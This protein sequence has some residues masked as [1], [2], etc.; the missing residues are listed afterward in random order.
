MWLEGQ[1]GGK[2]QHRDPNDVGREESTVV[3]MDPVK[4]QAVPLADPWN[5]S[6]GQRPNRRGE[7]VSNGGTRLVFDRQPA[8]PRAI[9]ELD[10]LHVERREHRVESAD[11]EKLFSIEH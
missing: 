10:V 3:Q 4:K 1:R 7:S 8:L 11:I 6:C 5:R 9:A 2:Q